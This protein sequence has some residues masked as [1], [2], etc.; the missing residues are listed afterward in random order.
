MSTRRIVVSMTENSNVAVAAPTKWMEGWDNIYKKMLEQSD[1]EIKDYD[2]P[3]LI[4]MLLHALAVSGHTDFSKVKVLE[5]ACGDGSG[6]C[7]L[8]KHGCKVEGVEALASAI[9]LARKRIKVLGLEEKASVH[10]GDIDDWELGYDMYDV[11]II[12]QSL[13]YLF[14]RT[15]PRLREILSAIK[16]GGFFVYSGNILPHFDTD[17]PIRFITEDELRKELN[18][19]TL[20]NFG[21][22]EVLLKP[23]DVRGYVRVIARKPE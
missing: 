3:Y 8:S 16:S 5:L 6:V 7:Y 9:E 12:L 15:I 19:W 1:E 2:A 17:P 13:Q 21:T 20:H 11:I 4:Q 23:N 10:L 18:G 14:D 22:E